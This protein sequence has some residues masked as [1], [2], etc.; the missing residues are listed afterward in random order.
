MGKQA[1]AAGKWIG[2]SLNKCLWQAQSFGNSWTVDD[3]IQEQKTLNQSLVGMPD[4]TFLL[5]PN[6][7]T[8]LPP[9]H[10][11]HTHKDTRENQWKSFSKAWNLAGPTVSTPPWSGSKGVKSDFG[12]LGRL[13]GDC[14]KG[15]L[16]LLPSGITKTE[17]A[18]RR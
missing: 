15:Y 11:C 9:P 18:S 4:F 2:F 8:P 3:W 10:S 7:N 6:H 13:S 17:I 16:H 5:P 14:S 12:R 1:G